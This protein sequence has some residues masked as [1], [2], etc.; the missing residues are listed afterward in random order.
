MKLLAHSN[1]HVP[2]NFKT[3]HNS[4]AVLIYPTVVVSLSIAIT[5]ILFI[6][7]TII[8]QL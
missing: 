7:T 4:T 1:I 6:I 8:A 3:L 5:G 2:Y